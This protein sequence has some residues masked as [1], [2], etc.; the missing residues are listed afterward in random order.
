MCD[1][2]DE[3]AVSYSTLAERMQRFRQEITSLEDDPRTDGPVTR[4][5]DRNIQAVSALIEENIHT[6]T[7]YMLYETSL[8]YGSRSNIM[9][10]EIKLKSYAQDGYHIS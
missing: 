3:D 7:R 5:P 9:N 6:S 4:A 1:A 8:S 2:L 10:V